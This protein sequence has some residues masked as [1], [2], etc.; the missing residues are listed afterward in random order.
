MWENLTWH[1]PL[2]QNVLVTVR[3][4]K[5][6]PTI[7]Q[8]PRFYSEGWSPCFWTLLML[9]FGTLAL[10]TLTKESLFLFLLVLF[11]K[12]SRQVRIL[13]YSTQCPPKNLLLVFILCWHA[14]GR[15]EQPVKHWC[16][17][18]EPR[19]AGW[20]QGSVPFHSFVTQTAEEKH[21]WACRFPRGK[22]VYEGR[23][24]DLPLTKSQSYTLQYSIANVFGFLS[25]IEKF[26]Q[27]IPREDIQ[28]GKPIFM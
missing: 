2:P 26:D 12:N 4:H 23:T 19:K 5:R 1:F 13:K 9:P 14:C 16:W 22:E 8:K 6:I 15:K 7:F 24:H 28:S 11:L 3:A 27:K 21:E 20:E 10:R 18:R 25:P 17:A